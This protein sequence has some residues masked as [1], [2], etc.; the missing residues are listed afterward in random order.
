MVRVISLSALNKSAIIDIR[1]MQTIAWDIDDVLNELM[2]SWLE[3]SWLP[4][5]PECS[6]RYE[7]ILENP[8]HQLLG[9]S[10]KQ[11][12]TSLD[13]FRLSGAV[14]KLPP[15]SEVLAWFHQYGK[16]F[17]H[18]T[19][20]AAP[21]CAVPISAAWVMQHFGTWVR[22]F[23]FVPS[24][25]QGEYIP[26]YDQSKDDFLRWWSKVDI[27]VDDSPINVEAAKALGIQAILM[28]RPWNQSQL[29]IT[30]TLSF[31]TKLA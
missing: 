3:Q 13:A 19:L 1:I 17:R 6:L 23:N 20:T 16:Q 12:L 29:T 24:K 14:A 11:Y 26:V 10:L 31:L 21:I 5:Y 22:S 2:Q 28:P 25:R 7:D 30:E 18:I 27:L 15:V 9:V 8:P 4:S